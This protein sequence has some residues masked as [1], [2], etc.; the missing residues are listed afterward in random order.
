[1]YVCNTFF[2]HQG[3]HRYKRVGVDI[4]VESRTDLV[5]ERDAQVYDG[6]EIHEGLRMGI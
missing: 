5:G 4:E 6:C 1:M 3:I 2:D